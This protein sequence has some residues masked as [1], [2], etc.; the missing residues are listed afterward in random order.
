[1]LFKEAKKILAN[2]KKELLGCDVDLVTENALP[3]A[4]R[5][6]IL[7]EAK[8]SSRSSE[9]TL[10]QTEMYFNFTIMILSRSN[11]HSRICVS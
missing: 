8:K 6:K 7:Q 5:E 10:N 9:A 11:P 4:L 1:M 3:P 2:H